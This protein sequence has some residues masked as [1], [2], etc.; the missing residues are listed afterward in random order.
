MNYIGLM[1][2]MWR[3]AMKSPM[4]ASEIALFAYLVNECNKR[5]W[6]MPFACSTTR[7]SDDLR[8]SRQTV[9]TAR[10]HLVKRRLISF[11]EGKSRHLPSTY[12]LTNWTDDLTV[13]LT[14]G[15]THIK[16]K[17][18]DNLIKG[19]SKNLSIKE[20]ERNNENNTQNRRRG[21]KEIHATAS[22][23]EGSF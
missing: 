2:Q 3:S 16:D 11:T 17:D 12:T 6:Q 19:D 8:V 9:I 23:Y 13:E 1:N 21:I 15:L 4:P 7:I 18:K 22:P 10:E 20:R 14:D 5:F